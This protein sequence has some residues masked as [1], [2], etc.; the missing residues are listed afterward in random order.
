MDL[1]LPAINTSNE[2]GVFGN[3]ATRIIKPTDGS[4]WSALDHVFSEATAAVMSATRSDEDYSYKTDFEIWRE[5]RKFECQNI[6][7]SRPHL[8]STTIGTNIKNV[9]TSQLESTHIGTKTPDPM[10]LKR[11]KESSKQKRKAHEPEDPESDPSLSASS[12]SK[13]DS[14]N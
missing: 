6:S 5:N 2:L 4:H 13:S 8:D 12:S 1:G 11:P 3:P 10:P 14:F 9:A 7:M